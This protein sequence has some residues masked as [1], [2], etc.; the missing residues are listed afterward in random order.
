MK[1]RHIILCLITALGMSAAAG[2]F[3]WLRA[4]Q[5]ALKAGQAMTLSDADMANY[6]R[7]SVAQMDAQNRTL[8]ATN[9]YSKRLKRLTAG[10]TKAGGITLNFKVYQT[11]EINAFAC[12]DGSVRVYT[13]IMDL[14]TDDELLG[15]IGHE[16]GHV[17]KH[18]SRKA[19]QKQLLRSAAGDALSAG[20]STIAGIT[21]SQLGAIGQMMMNARYSRKQETEADNCGYDF[22]VSKGKNPAC[23][24][25]AFKKMQ[26]LEQKQNRLSQGMALM[27]SDHPD[28]QSR[29]N[30]LTK[31]CIKDGYMRR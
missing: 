7:Q 4:A 19:L 23:M 2:E 25:S 8:P 24:V 13:G 6:V 22:L 30:N 20:S 1:I 31:R 14:M 9:A 18:H 3:D 29:I 26:K 17:M 28:T 27:F 10:L 12:P 11:Q 16:L 15:I 21:D 5:G